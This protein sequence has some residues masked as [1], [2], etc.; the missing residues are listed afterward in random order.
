MSSVYNIASDGFN[1]HSL[2]MGTHCGT[3]IDAPYH[4]CENGKKLDEL[5]FES[6]VGRAII[7]DIRQQVL[8]ATKGIQGI[9]ARSQNKADIVLFW[10][11][12]DTYW[13]TAK[14]FEHPYLSKEVAVQLTRLGA[15][16]VGVDTFSPDE[17]VME[18]QSRHQ[19]SD[20]FGVHETLLG[21]DCL[22]CENLKNLGELA[23]I[24]DNPEE[25]IW[26]SLMPMNIKGADGAPV[27]AYGWRS[28]PRGTLAT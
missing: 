9:G 18:G 26:V 15:R 23:A 4:F 17:T 6:F 1:L 22:I 28:R 20:P 2:S 21:N 10:T 25:E 3:H 27:R 7:V 14:Y 13:G 11:G 5:D 12:W 8:S 16:F 19:H 24:G